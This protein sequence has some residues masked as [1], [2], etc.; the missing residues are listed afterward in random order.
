MDE[1]QTALAEDI[2]AM[3]LGDEAKAS[4]QA[5]IQGFIDGAVGMFRPR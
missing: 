3:D 1:P 2:E 4:A 5:T